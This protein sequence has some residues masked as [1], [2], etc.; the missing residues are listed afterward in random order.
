MKANK[1]NKVVKTVFF[2]GLCLGS[3]AAHFAGYQT[4]GNLLGGAAGATLIA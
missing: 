4:V 2:V 1:T 3:L